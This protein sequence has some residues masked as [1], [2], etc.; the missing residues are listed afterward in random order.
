M[1]PKTSAGNPPRAAA[2]RASDNVRTTAGT[3]RPARRPCAISPGYNPFPIPPVAPARLPQ[4]DAIAPT[5][6]WCK[7][8]ELRSFHLIEML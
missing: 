6:G 7:E 1:N 5:L 2:G 3:T 4:A 8:L